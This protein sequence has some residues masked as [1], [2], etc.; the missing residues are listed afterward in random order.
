MFR[1]LPG[2]FWVLRVKE[3]GE[4]ERGRE[5]RRERRRWKGREGGR[6]DEIYNQKGN[7]T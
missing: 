1:M 7:R 2:F 5:R 4:R 6:K 3:S